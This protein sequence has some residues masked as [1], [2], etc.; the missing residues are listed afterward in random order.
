MISLLYYIVQVDNFEDSPQQVDYTVGAS[1]SL[2]YYS[3]D[4]IP[5]SYIHWTTDTVTNDD[6]HTYSVEYT[7]PILLS[8]VYS[9]MGAG[10]HVMSCFYRMSPVNYLGSLDLA[11][12][13]NILST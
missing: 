9:D 7:N 4:V 6:T 3:N 13:G 1:A 11:I 10:L 12:K 8:T 5:D 2:L